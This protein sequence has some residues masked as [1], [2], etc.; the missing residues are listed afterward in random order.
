MPNP[1][2]ASR[3]ADMLTDG[4]SIDLIS[5]WGLRSGW[6]RQDVKDVVAAKG[7]ALDWE[8]R[9]QGRY[10]AQQAIEQVPCR[11][12]ADA[13]SDRLIMV[14]MDHDQVD[15]KRQA[16]KAQR[17]VD[18]LRRALLI[19]EQKDMENVVR[20]RR[21]RNQ[22]LPPRMECETVPISVSQ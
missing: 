12:I 17:A 19:Q 8:G 9:L 4:Y 5:E 11:S 18:E 1:A 22:P 10:R 21:E 20:R 16:V 7:W 13:D 15:I 14:G 3:I 6:T 2:R